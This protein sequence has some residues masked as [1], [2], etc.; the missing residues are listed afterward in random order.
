MDAGMAPLFDD[1]RP[2]IPGGVDGAVER[3][4]VVGAGIA[5][6]TVANALAHAGVECVVLEARDRIGGRLHTVDLAGSRVDLGGSWIHH[7][8]GNPMHR[9]AQAA[10]IACRPATPLPTLTGFD[11][12]TGLRLS[13][14]EVEATLTPE[15]DGFTRA[16]G[17]LRTQL[18]PN[19]SA[20]DGIE[21]FLAA[22]GLT[23]DPLRRA[24]QGLRANVEADAAGAAE[25]QSLEWLWTQEEYGGDYFGVQPEGGYAT[26][27]DAMAAG[28]DVRRDW[29]VSGV[30]VADGGVSVTSQSGG[31]E[32]GSH[33]VVAV[34]LGVLKAGRPQFSPALPV[35]RTEAVRRLGFG[36][37]EKVLLA[38]DEPFW[39]RVG[40]SHLVLFTPDAAEPAS[41]VL[42][43]DAFGGGP[44]LACH[45]FHS[46]T[47]H[48]G[49]PAAST[50]WVMDMLSGALGAP[51]PEPVAVMVTDWAGDACAEGSYTHVPPG[52]SNSDLDLLGRPVAGRLLFA[53]E[54]TQSARLGYADGA[55]TSGIREAKRLLGTAA[56]SLGPLSSS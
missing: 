54:H 30:D 55:M 15:L 17:P 37:Y 21:A 29:A 49:S 24:A 38:F 45:T 13:H 32:R 36:R 50:R 8:T 48:L 12:A 31:T 11:C 26:V 25:R 46:A 27:V 9:F 22:S 43:L 41:W 39:R 42:D 19:A 5:G 53:G 35:E 51:C 34:P 1:G 28:L 16:L 44:V 3:V 14:D 20:A 10:G 47:G 56:V 7:P 33:V 52:C 4:L 6:L 40:W 23:G 2:E 18:G